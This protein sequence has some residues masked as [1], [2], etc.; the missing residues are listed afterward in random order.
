MN[1]GAF[2]SHRESSIKFGSIGP[3][4]SQCPQVALINTKHLETGKYNQILRQAA[5][6]TPPPKR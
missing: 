1:E 3:T 6:I 2:Y 5:S 4:F